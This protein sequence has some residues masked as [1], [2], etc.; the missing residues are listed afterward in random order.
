MSDAKA[1]LRERERV[2]AVMSAK[3]GKTR[4]LTRFPSTKECLKGEVNANSNILQDLRMDL[5][6]GGTLLFQQWVRG[7]LPIARQTGPI[8]LI[9]GFSLLKQVVVQP[10]AFIKRFIQLVGLL[11]CRENPVLKNF[12][13]IRILYLNGTIVKGRECRSTQAPPKRN[14][15]HPPLKS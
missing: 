3:P 11:L 4:L 9:G 7:L 8:L 1:A 5:F 13:H 2:V 10:T 15:F 12:K 6:E 14:A